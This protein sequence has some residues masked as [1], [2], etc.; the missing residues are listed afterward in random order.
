MSNPYVEAYE[1]SIKDPDAFWAKA[2][3][4][5]H[6][7]KKWDKVLDDSNKPFYRWFTGGECNTCYNALD[8]HIENGRGDKIALI[9]DSPVH[10]VEHDHAVVVHA[11][12]AGGVDPVALPAAL[13]QLRQHLLG[14]V[15]ALAGHDRVERLELL[16]EDRDPCR[17]RV[18]IGRRHQLGDP[19]GDVPEG[20]GRRSRL[21]LNDH[22]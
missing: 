9:Y 2:A 8:L 12:G 15:A 17:A 1:Q 21:I 14:V 10:R 3:E 19:L 13:P 20:L 11:L 4:E 18:L 6:W 5:C 16:F 7:N 22:R